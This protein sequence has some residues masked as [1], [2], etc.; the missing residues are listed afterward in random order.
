M[1][2]KE[3]GT[4]SCRDW[5][6]FSDFGFYLEMQGHFQGWRGKWHDLI[7]VVKRWSWPLCWEQPTEKW[8][9]EVEMTLRIYS[10]KGNKWLLASPYT[11]RDSFSG[12]Q[13]QREKITTFLGAYMFLLIQREIGLKSFSLSFQLWQYVNHQSA[14]FY[15]KQFPQDSINDF[16]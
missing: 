14:H 11:F 1:F 6:A 15:K 12:Y 8:R 3:K 9:A 4:E 2:E 10:R 16:K 5:Q 7:Y 13:C